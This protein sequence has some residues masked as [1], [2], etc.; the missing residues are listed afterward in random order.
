MT[1]IVCEVCACV[2]LL[3]NRPCLATSAPQSIGAL[4]ASAE[5]GEEWSAL[6][7]PV[8]KLGKKNLDRYHLGE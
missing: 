3:N 6:T 2:C 4:S 7:P 1:L 8:H 5:H